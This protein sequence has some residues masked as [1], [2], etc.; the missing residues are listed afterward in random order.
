MGKGDIKSRK[1]KRFAGSKGKCTK[2]KKN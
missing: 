1:G 2:K